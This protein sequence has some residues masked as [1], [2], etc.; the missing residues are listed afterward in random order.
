M[1]GSIKK[2]HHRPRTITKGIRSLNID[3]QPQTPLVPFRNDSMSPIYSSPG[4]S[5]STS[6]NSLFTDE[7]R[8]SKS[9]CTPARSTDSTEEAWD[10]VEELPHR[11]A[12]DYVSLAISGSRLAN[13]S[14]LFYDIWSDPAT[15]GRKGALLAAATKSSILLYETPKGERAFRFVKVSHLHHL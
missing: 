6:V 15:A 1:R 13:T 4:I 2:G 8:A 3:N 14:V 9:P 10:I 7:L 11:W 12:T 5:P